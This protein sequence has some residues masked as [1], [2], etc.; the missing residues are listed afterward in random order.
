MSMKKHGMIFVNGL[1]VVA[2]II[3][4]AYVLGRAMWWFDNTMRQGLDYIW[5]RSFPGLGIAVGVAAIYLVGLLAR[6]WLFWVLIRAGESIVE[7]IPLV[8]SLY[9]AVRDLLQFLGGSR[10]D[11]RGKPAVLR[12]KDG[13]TSMLGILTQDKPAGF[14]TGSDDMVGIY[15]PM[16]YQLGGYTL[17]VSKEL[18][19]EVKELSVENLL[20]L[21]L[22]AGVTTGSPF[23]DKGHST[24][25]D[26]N[27]KS[28]MR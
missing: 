28:E 12:S 25:P 17:Y 10:A 2:P 8:K 18:V 21:A 4:T 20:K 23:K 11:R 27:F 16:S 5:G 1:I 19:Q 26:R 13:T 14:L 7:R 3:I 15:L 9:S 22:T 24:A 6:T